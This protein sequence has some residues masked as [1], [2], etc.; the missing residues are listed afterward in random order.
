VA[1][2]TGTPAVYTDAG[3]ALADT[4]TASAAGLELVLCVA[5]RGTTGTSPSALT[6]GGVV[7]VGASAVGA[8]ITELIGTASGQRVHRWYH[9]PR[10]FHPGTG[11][12]AVA[13]AW[14]GV[15]NIA[16]AILEVSATGTITFPSSNQAASGTVAITAG[17]GDLTIGCAQGNSATPAFAPVNGQTE[18]LESVWF[19]S[20][21]HVVGVQT[22][23]QTAASWTGAGSICASAFVVH[24][25]S[26]SSSYGVSTETDT[27]VALVG[28][29]H[30][31]YVVTTETDSTVALIGSNPGAYGVATET[32]SAVA[33]TAT[34]QAAFGV[35]TETD[36][37]VALAG[38]ESVAYGVATETDSAIALETG[39]I[40]PGVSLGTDSAVALI[41]SDRASYGIATESGA[42]VAL[43]GSAHASYGTSAETDSAV[44]LAGSLAAAYGIATETDLAVALTVP[45]V[46]TLAPALFTFRDPVDIALLADAQEPTTY[47]DE[48]VATIA[49]D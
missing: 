23:T 28:S 8:P 49:Y 36:A 6:Y 39:D 38:F 44:A 14:A 41:G 4:H 2:I 40:Y 22:G 15:D 29:A 48:S 47:R 42:S 20:S 17:S 1:S 37:A 34:N 12:H 46:H 18:Y 26:S 5:E 21:G 33:L 35:S 19:A 32:D 43:V 10:A 24:E 11:T 13:C 7:I 3:T 30:A 16:V 45:S 31:T 27:A 25:E 9:L